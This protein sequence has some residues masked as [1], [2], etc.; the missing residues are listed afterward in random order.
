MN[1]INH[2]LAS[3]IALIF[4]SAC[5][6]EEETTAP[7]NETGNT[8]EV[9]SGGGAITFTKALAVES[10]NDPVRIAR[11][12]KLSSIAYLDTEAGS[13]NYDYRHNNNDGYYISVND[14]IIHTGIDY[15]GSPKN[16]KIGSL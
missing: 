8:E 14:G 4:L 5:E 12:Q 1:K 2:S 9:L 11:M 7:V 10:D 13:I 3:A 6:T 15:Q 16:S